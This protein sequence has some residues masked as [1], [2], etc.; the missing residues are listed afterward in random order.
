ML[1]GAIALTLYD[2][3]LMFDDEVGEDV[4]QPLLSNVLT[5]FFQRFVTSGKAGRLGV[6]SVV[7]T[8]RR[9]S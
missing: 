2:Y 9:E 1:I 6:R 8:A 4:N 5:N 3:L 7:C